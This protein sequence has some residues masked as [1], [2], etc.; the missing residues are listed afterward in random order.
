MCE[1]GAYD[2]ISASSDYAREHKDQDK[3]VKGEKIKFNSLKLFHLDASLN[4]RFNIGQNSLN[5]TGFYVIY[6]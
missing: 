3:N 1:D 2:N 4:L 5:Y 6:M